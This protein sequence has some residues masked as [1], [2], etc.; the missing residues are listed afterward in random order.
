MSKKKQFIEE[1]IDY[2]I[3]EISQKFIQAGISGVCLYASA[4]LKEKLDME[5]ISL[6]FV[7]GYLQTNRGGGE[8]FRHVWL[9]L[10]EIIYDVSIDI[11]KNVSWQ[12]LNVKYL[13]HKTLPHNLRRTDIMTDVLEHGI[14][15]YQINPYDFWSEFDNCKRPEIHNLIAP[16]I[17]KLRDSFLDE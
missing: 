8:V 14:S 15:L 17:N 1:R 11:L 12:S 16:T 10:N 6:N 2:H 4:I 7:P 9:E 3:K 13:Y 5:G